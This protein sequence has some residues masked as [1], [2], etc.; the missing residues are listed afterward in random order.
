MSLVPIIYPFPTEDCQCPDNYTGRSCEDCS[1]GFTLSSRL[2]TDTCVRCDCNNQSSDCDPLTG[3]CVN[4]QGNTQG[5]HCEQCA[6]GYYGD[7]TRGIECLLCRCPL[8]AN[9]FSATCY[10]NETDGLPVCD[11]C[12]TGYTGRN[13]ELCMNGY[14]G[15]PL[16]SISNIPL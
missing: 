2:P 10:L 3:V 4:C 13:C 7:P 12:A 15:S 11:N 6:A 9:S 16:V 8:V 5:E 1:E 14:F